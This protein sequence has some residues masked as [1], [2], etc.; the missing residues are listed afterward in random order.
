[1]AK[2]LYSDVDIL[3]L[4]LIIKN[5][6]IMPRV[7]ENVIYN[8]ALTL[9]TFL[10]NLVLFP[11]V[12][13]VLGVEYVG[14]IGFVNNVI[15]YFSLFA[16]WGIRSI[17]I[18]EI[19]ACGNDYNKRSEVFSSLLFFL[20]ITTLIITIGYFL[21]VFFVPRFKADH[22]LLLLG[23]ITLFFTSFLIE[24]FYQGM[25][26][27][28]F[29]TI[30]TVVIKVIYAILVFILIKNKDSYLLYFA[31]TV[32]VV[33]INSII[34]LV[35]SRNFVRFS[36]KTIH[37]KQYIQPLFSLGLY[38]I[39]LSMYTTFN[40][41][42]LGFV[43]SDTEV[44]YYYTSTTI[45]QIIIGIIA[46]F[47]GVM[48][49]RISNLLNTNHEQEAN[50]KIRKSIE[51]MIFVALPLGIFFFCMAPHVVRLISGVGYEGAVLPM[52][53]IMPVIII[54]SLAQIWVLQILI[55]RK[56]DKVV[57]ISATIGA[58]VGVLAN[59][60]LVKNYG[61]IGSAMVLLLSELCGNLYS[62]IYAIR[63]KYLEFPHEL[64]KKIIP[65]S[66]PFLVVCNISMIFSEMWSLIL[67]LL[68]CATFFYIYHVFYYRTG[69]I[70]EYILLMKNKLLKWK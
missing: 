48:M 25:E 10:I 59:L 16:I 54:A 43:C 46:A 24:W 55:P 12:S 7:A 51:L 37:L 34:N 52:R 23:S 17:G 40:V 27:F 53:I 11:Y 63:K 32:A 2:V 18:R 50:E 39:V 4:F 68:T 13:R 45:Y 36:I 20:F 28:K 70:G 69:V 29:I 14:K 64:I 33:L 22:S 61:A 26:N 56:K 9:S 5:N 66:I 67:C 21:S 19:A 31:L 47:T 8:V 58:F 60:V 44:G 38:N 41:V 62:M 30:R 15:S 49:P 6:L 65:Y 42:Y 3:N 1:M 57:L 35:Y